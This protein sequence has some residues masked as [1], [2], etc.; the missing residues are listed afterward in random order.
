M[1]FDLIGRSPR[2]NTGTYFRRSVWGWRPIWE[3]IEDI[4]SDLL[5]EDDLEAGAW[6]EGRVIPEHKAI[7]L[8]ARLYEELT[9]GHADRYILDRDLRLKAL[10]D[11]PCE[12]CQGTGARPQDEWWDPTSQWAKVCGGCNGCKGTGTRRPAET[13]YSLERADLEEFA[14]FCEASGGFEIW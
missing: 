9:N 11:E 2:G 13:Y 12:L 6:N 10:L 7:A 1:G 5:S 4:A 8:A 14:A 3:Y